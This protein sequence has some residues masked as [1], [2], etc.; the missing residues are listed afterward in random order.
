MSTIIQTACRRETWLFLSD[1]VQWKTS[2]V[3]KE[4]CDV[5]QHLPY[6]TIATHRVRG[7]AKTYG[8]QTSVLC[9]TQQLN[10]QLNPVD[11]KILHFLWLI[12]QHYA[13]SIYKK[14]M[15]AVSS[16][17][18]CS[19]HFTIYSPLD[20]L[21]QIPSQNPREAFSHAEINIWR[22]FIVS[23]TNIHLSKTVKPATHLYRQVN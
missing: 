10:Q 1:H 8:F 22:L 19:K 13:Y 17:Q 11:S 14:E 3:N 9:R 15:F 20:R 6:I 21:N 4:A 7:G 2:C 18:E 5:H 23:Y 16:L 12:I